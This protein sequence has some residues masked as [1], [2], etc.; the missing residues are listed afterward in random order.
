MARI[1][2]ETLKELLRRVLR[3]RPDEVGCETCYESL[4]RF[5]ELELE[6]KDA[7]QALPLIQRHLEVCTGCHDE[8]EALLTALQTLQSQ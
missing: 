8:Y 5:V 1:Q 2:P 6:G 7:K 4:E 3:T